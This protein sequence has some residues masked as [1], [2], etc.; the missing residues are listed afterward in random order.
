[1]TGNTVRVRLVWFSPALVGS[2]LTLLVATLALSLGAVPC[3]AD[4][5]SSGGDAPEAAASDSTASSE[6]GAPLANH[7]QVYYF[8]RT[9][10]CDTCLKFEAYA[11]EAIRSRF[12][13]ELAD[14]RLVWSILN[15]DDESSTT[16]VDAYDIFESSLVVS[17]VEAGEERSWEKLET[18]WGLVG[19]KPTFLSYIQGEVEASLS[20][21]RKPD[22]PC[23]SVRDSV[24]QPNETPV[25][26]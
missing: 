24:A 20:E 10:R 18:I 21:A 13:E 9:L 3:R 15:L 14:G 4:G 16:L 12:A 1:M 2:F 22:L 26:R 19:D 25:R 23:G 17:V 8:H 11:E 5:A 7:V 6:L